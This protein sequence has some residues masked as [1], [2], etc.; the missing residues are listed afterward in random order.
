MKFITRILRNENI[1]RFIS[2][3]FFYI[4][5]MNNDYANQYI[6]FI[7]FAKMFKIM[8]EIINFY[9]LY[10]YIIKG[11]LICNKKKTIKNI[12]FEICQAFAQL[13]SNL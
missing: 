8:K 12:Q 4:T 2:L 9:L 5:N 13:K 6:Y 11:K 1:I 10:W 3:K 7:N